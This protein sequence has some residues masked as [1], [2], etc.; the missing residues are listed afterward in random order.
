MLK[1]KYKNVKVQTHYWPTIRY[2]IEQ[3]PIP[4]WY[5]RVFKWI[6]RKIDLYLLKQ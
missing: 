6:D 5:E 3:Q 2:R 1:R 4:F